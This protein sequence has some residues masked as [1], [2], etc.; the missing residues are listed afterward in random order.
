MRVPRCELDGFASRDPDC[1]A[2]AHAATERQLARLALHELVIGRL[3][4]E[5]RLAS[6]FVLLGR[7]AGQALAGDRIVCQIP[8]NRFEIAD[9]LAIN[10]DT[11]SRLF[12]RLRRTG[13]LSFLGRRSAVIEDWR[14]LC[15]RTPVADA[16]MRLYRPAGAPGQ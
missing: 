14:G 7:A 15:A 12:A 2:Y 1:A 4:G 11:L 6:F 16:L 3:S 5:E 9:Y 10:P 13:V 8:L